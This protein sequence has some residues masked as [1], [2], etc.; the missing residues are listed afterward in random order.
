MLLVQRRYIDNRDMHMLF[1]A[2]LGVMK[3]QFFFA[4]NARTSL[5]VYTTALFYA[6]VLINYEWGKVGRVSCTRRPL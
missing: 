5:N 6:Q 3:C 2:G 1:V 4:K